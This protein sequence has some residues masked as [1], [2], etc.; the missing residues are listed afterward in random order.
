M[1]ASELDRRE[2]DLVAR[3]AELAAA[4]WR[5]ERLLDAKVRDL[6]EALEI[7]RAAFPDGVIIAAR[8][9]GVSATLH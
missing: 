1:R 7:V 9:G 4:R 8:E 2:A 3:E 6:S 5:L